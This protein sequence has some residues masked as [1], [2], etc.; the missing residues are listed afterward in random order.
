M[1]EAKAEA[2][3]AGFTTASR[4]AAVNRNTM[5]SQ[6]TIMYPDDHSQRSSLR[7]IDDD[8]R[9]LDDARAEVLRLENLRLQ[10]DLQIQEERRR[11]EDLRLQ[12]EVNARL[13]EDVRRFSNSEVPTREELRLRTDIRR[14]QNVIRQDEL[15]SLRMRD[16]EYHRRGSLSPLSF[17]NL[18]SPRTRE[19]D[20]AR[21]EPLSPLRLDNDLHYQYVRN[22]FAPRRREPMYRD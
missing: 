6:R 5:P 15:P 3:A 12:E 8:V 14:A 4:V 18:P 7:S 13:R 17:D 9:A 11:R 20:Y 1:S 22:P 19:F 10:D 2:F 21:M 16:V